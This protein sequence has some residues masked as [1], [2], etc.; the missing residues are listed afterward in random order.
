MSNMSRR[1]YYRMRY[2]QAGI[3]PT[4]MEPQSVFDARSMDYGIPPT[5]K[6]IPE[7]KKARTISIK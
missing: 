2:G 5:G 6:I 1:D 4:E 3:D 7:S